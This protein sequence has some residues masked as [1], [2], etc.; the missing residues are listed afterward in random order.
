MA[1][2]THHTRCEEKLFA[3]SHHC[4]YKIVTF[5]IPVVKNVIFLTKIAL[6]GSLARNLR[7]KYLTFQRWGTEYVLIANHD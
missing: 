7:R 5:E 6:F 2:Q 1:S 4:V 3:P